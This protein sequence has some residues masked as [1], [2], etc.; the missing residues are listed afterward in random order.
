LSFFVVVIAAD[1]AA[2][3][4]ILATVAV[5]AAVVHREYQRFKV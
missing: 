1:A 3:A 4:G 2:D 5:V